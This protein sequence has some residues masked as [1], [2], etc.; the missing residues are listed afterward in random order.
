MVCGLLL[1]GVLL[2]LSHT[3]AGSSACRR[4]VL[5]QRPG[6]VSSMVWDPD[7]R[8]L[9][10]TDVTTRQLLR[11][12]P[13]GALLGAV[14][15]PT[16]YKREFK[17]TQ[18][19]AR[20]E[21]FLVRSGARDWIWFDRGFGF[22]RAV[23]Q[24]A[25]PGF[26]LINEVWGK[27][28]RLTGFG[29]FRKESGAWSWGF[30]QARFDVPGAEGLRVLH[31]VSYQSKGGDL[32][33]LLTTVTAMAGE[34]PFALRFDEP[35]YILNLDNGERLR[36]FPAGF[37]RLPDLPK[38][39]GEESA[40]RRLRVVDASSLPVALYG[41]GNFLYLLTREPKSASHRWRLHRI[42]PSRDRLLDSVILPTAAPF[43]EMAPGPTSWA[44]LEESRGDA[45]RLQ[46]EGLLL[47]A[48][49]AIDGGGEIGACE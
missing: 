3:G 18:V 19:H 43:L 16:S 30:L 11:Y 26:T 2:P 8:E 32:A 38:N 5:A 27:A 4:I 47:I 42:D 15:K 33:L 14:E 17:P 34:T 12:S 49:S 7:G 13:G 10:L 45:G 29:S 1:V 48:I 35:S 23:V 21:G 37:D 9:V 41:Q 36:A 31:E 24:A 40:S 46:G 44:L 22:L 39:E 6:Q 20:P 25:P 28:D